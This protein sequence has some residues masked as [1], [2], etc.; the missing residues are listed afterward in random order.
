M[1][2]TEAQSAAKLSQESGFTA[3]L[4]LSYDAKLEEIVSPH[5]IVRGLDVDAVAR[6]FRRQRAGRVVEDG[7]AVDVEDRFVVISRYSSVS[8]GNLSTNGTMVSP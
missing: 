3:F 7:I 6:V 5:R 4:K 1:R 8:C 2:P